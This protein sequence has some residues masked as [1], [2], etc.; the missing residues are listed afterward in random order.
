MA[1]GC[2]IPAMSRANASCQA[3]S[4]FRKSAMLLS[5]IYMYKISSGIP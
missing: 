2:S 4:S 5:N 1:I 3:E